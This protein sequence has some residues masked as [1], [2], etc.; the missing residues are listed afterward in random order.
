M[1]TVPIQNAFL[2]RWANGLIVAMAKGPG[3]VPYDHAIGLTTSFFGEIHQ[4][5]DLHVT[6]R[7][8]D[9]PC[10]TLI[11]EVPAPDP[12]GPIW[13][14]NHLPNWQLN[15]EYE[16]DLQTVAAAQAIEG[17][18]RERPQHVVLAGDLDADPAADIIRF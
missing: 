1:T 4:G 17:L 9:F 13:F 15:F 7:T 5:F 10:T 18:W 3:H 12:I 14:V 8:A 2:R 6:V 16:P 11:V